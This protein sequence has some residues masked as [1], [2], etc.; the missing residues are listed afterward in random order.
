MV[1]MNSAQKPSWNDTYLKNQVLFI[2]ENSNKLSQYSQPLVAA[3]MIVHT[4]KSSIQALDIANKNSIS[5][6]VVDED[7][8]SRSLDYLAQLVSI[9]PRSRIVSIHLNPIGSSSFMEA[10]TK[11]ALTLRSSYG[12]GSIG[13]QIIKYFGKICI[14]PNKPTEGNNFGLVGDTDCVKRLRSKISRLKNVPTNILIH[15]ESGTGKELVAKALHHESKRHDK[16]FIAINCGAI[17][18]SLLESELFGH[19]KGAFTDAKQNR[20][21]VFE[22][23]CGG[24]LFLDEIGEMPIH[25][26]VKLL[27]ILQEMVVVPLGCT[28]PRKINT[29]VIAATNKDLSNLVANGKFREDLYFRLNVLELE[30]KPLRE[31]R[32]DIHLIVDHFIDIFNEKYECSFQAPAK[33]TLDRLSQLPWPGNVRQLRSHVER[34]VLLSEGK[35]LNEEELFP[36]PTKNSKKTESKIYDFENGDILKYQEIRAALDKSYLKRLLQHTRGNIAEAS[37]FSGL[38]RA[39]IYRMLERY[40]I[41]ADSF[42]PTYLSDDL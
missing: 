38:Y 21:G 42:K 12:M 26:Q 3:G 29:R 16:P 35:T 41:E 34:A 39:N 7:N 4:A 13:I 1:L 18:E 5:M 11:A 8:Y 9:H 2:G 37:R 10:G 24:T 14:S 27:R 25:L 15:G 22:A 23:A 31:R 32:E 33:K 19:V 6:I 30:I 40:G 17:P 36:G 28:I 20:K